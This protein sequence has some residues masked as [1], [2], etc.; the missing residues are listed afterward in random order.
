MSFGL[1]QSVFDDC[2]GAGGHVRGV[3]VLVL[4]GVLVVMLVGVTFVILGVI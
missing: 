1:T 2:W 3:L 4:G